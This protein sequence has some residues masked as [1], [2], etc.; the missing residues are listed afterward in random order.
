[1][2]LY[3]QFGYGMM[4]HSEA[5]LSEWKSGGVI[6]SPRDLSPEQLPRVA[7]SALRAGAEP[8]LDP[9]CFSRAAD[10][11][12]LRSHAYWNEV[13]STSTKSM[14]TPDGAR[15]VVTRILDLG[16]QLGTT[17]TILPGLLASKI[18][19][20]WLNVQQRIVDA[21]IESEKAGSVIQTVALSASVLR[22]ES[23]VDRILEASRSWPDCTAYVVAEAPTSYLVDD[24]I[25]LGQLLVL[26]AGLRLQKKQVIVGYTNH[27]GLCLAASGVNAIAS[28]TWLNVRA[29]QPDKFF[30][31]ADDEISRRA[32]GGW[33]FCPQAL[34]EFKMPFLDVAKKQDILDRMGPKTDAA[35]RYGMP[36]FGGAQPSVVNWGEKSGFRHYLTCLREEARTLAKGSFD[37]VVAELK[38]R[39]AAAKKLIA[40][41]HASGVRGQDRDFANYVDVSLASISLLDGAL[42]PRL[43][44]AWPR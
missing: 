4:A 2:D 31:S 12:R 37:A 39:L 20:P 41:L 21:A 16:R 30:V 5:L 7:E 6:L 27:Q 15:R 34:S 24:P 13:A 32:K 17:R 3:L 14:A 43:R 1:M 11:A 18:D 36:L 29:F 40:D 19:K 42:G 22:D 26:C 38:Q 23:S 44:R 33:Y 8:L 9:Q 28:G 25:W 10:H 35:K